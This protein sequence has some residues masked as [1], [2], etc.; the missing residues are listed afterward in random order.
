[1]SFVKVYY[2]VSAILNLILSY[3]AAILLYH[4][5]WTAFNVLACFAGLTAWVGFGAIIRSKGWLWS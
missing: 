1:M 4:E 2:I 5:N 3:A